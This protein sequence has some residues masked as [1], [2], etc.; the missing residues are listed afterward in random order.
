MTS[1]PTIV[2]V[3]FENQYAPVGG[4]AAV[5]KR[6]PVE[7]GKSFNTLLI[8][9]YFRNIEKTKRA[10]R[11]GLIED[12]GMKARIF[13]HG[14]FCPIEVLKKKSGIEDSN[15]TTYFIKSNGFFLASENPYIDTWRIEGLFHDSYF[16]CKCV[17]AILKLV[18]KSHPPPYIFSL[19]D[20]EAALTVETTFS[21]KDSKCFLTM[22]NAY[23]YNLLGDFEGRTI[24][25]Y[26]I[27]QMQGISTVSRQ[28]AHELT[29][30]VLQKDLFARK[31]QNQLSAHGIIGINNGA[32]VDLHFPKTIT[33]DAEILS[34]KRK[35]RQYFTNLV[36]EK[37]LL[38]PT[39]GNQIDLTRDKSET[40]VFLLFGRDAPKQKGI[41]VAAAAIYRL[42]KRQDNRKAIFIFAIVPGSNG[43]DGL[44]YLEELAGEFPNN[45]MVFPER[46]A[47]G[48]QELQS[49]ANFIIMPSYYEPFGAA[50]EGYGAGTPVIARATGG[51]M[52]Q[53][54]PINYEKLPTHVKNLLV[55][56]HGKE[57][58]ANPTGFLYVEDPSVETVENWK[59][60]LSTDVSKRRSVKEPV[61]RMNP[62]FWS[63]VTELEMVIDQAIDFY[64]TEKKSYCKM[65]LNGITLFEH[66]NWENA[67]KHYSRDLFKIK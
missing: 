36:S 38:S 11:E 67:A 12:T 51:L 42:L 6:L 45:I 2:L 50:N 54:S 23:D 30:Q 57:G 58:I 40:P 66:F 15:F 14:A 44:A 56:Y 22:H 21:M 39:W 62:I 41:D 24:L 28:F 34:E 55:I 37:K 33:S 63:M 8:T 25:Q 9:P 26:S 61:D 27:P 19:H 1:S 3:A 4:L 16:L 20:W 29:H 43:L 31:I 5:M 49:A 53:V 48:Y 7:L 10:Y 65:I 17:P 52:E 18:E 13:Y 46:L 47:K 32:F 59:Y 35:M 64:Q 60:L